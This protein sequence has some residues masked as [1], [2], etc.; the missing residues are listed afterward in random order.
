MKLLAMQG[1]PGLERYMLHRLKQPRPSL[2][3]IVAA[4]PASELYTLLGN[5]GASRF[6]HCRLICLAWCSVLQRSDGGTI[7]LSNMRLWSQGRRD[8]WPADHD[9]RGLFSSL[10]YGLV[11][12]QSCLSV[13]GT[14]ISLSPFLWR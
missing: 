2:R 4:E 8:S 14:G 6:A 3:N 1:S 10:Q 7:S 5:I 9:G 11:A 13:P 12:R